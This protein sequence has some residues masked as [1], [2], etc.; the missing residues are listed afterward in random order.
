MSRN[1]EIII[2]F[3]PQEFFLLKEA[4]D[5]MC[6]DSDLIWGG[7]DDHT[8]RYEAAMRLAARLEKIEQMTVI[9]H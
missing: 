5:E 1:R 8:I 7:P 9:P 2:P 3:S 4:M 6:N